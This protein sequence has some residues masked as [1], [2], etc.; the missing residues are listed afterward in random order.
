[1]YGR[2]L[3]NG[4]EIVRVLHGTRDIQSILAEVFGLAGDASS[5]EMIDQDRCGIGTSAIAVRGMI[6][7]RSDSQG[8]RT[9]ADHQGYGI[10]S[11]DQCSM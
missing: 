8:I 9:V 7:D 3:A 4:I 10:G 2:P 6:G 1:M 11:T 5:E